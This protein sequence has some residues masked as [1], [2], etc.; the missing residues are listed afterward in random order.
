[1]TTTQWVWRE[2][3]G[4]PENLPPEPKGKK[5]RFA[6]DAQCWLCG[7]D[8]AGRGWHFKDVIGSA[9]T[10]FN[11][12]KAPHS[13]AICGSCAALMKKECW[14]QACE[15]HGHSPFFPV[16]DDKKPFL[17]NW[18]FSS[19]VFSAEGWERP[20]RKAAREVLLDPPA[21][22]FVI[23]LAAAGKKHVIF[24]ARLNHDRQQFTVQL[25]DEELMVDCLRF[26]EL[27]EAFEAAYALGFSKD[28]LLTGHYNQA[29]VLKLGV[30]RWREIEARMADWRRRH[31]GLMR[32]AHFCGQ[33]PEET[34]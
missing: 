5:A 9:F 27:L 17:A 2:C 31:P 13:K 4:M 7:G 14:E 18:M 12:A 19:H 10:D 30:G 34:P 6:D 29:A 16:K 33:K 23:T 24:R 32:L 3:L 22:P 26:A 15:A 28:S 20:D 1:M 25:D 21:P 8:T 11:A